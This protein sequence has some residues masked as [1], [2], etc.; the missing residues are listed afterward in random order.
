MPRPIER[1]TLSITAFPRRADLLVIGGGLGGVA[2]AMTAVRLGQTVILVERGDWLGGQW[3]AQAVPPDESPWVEEVASDSY[4]RLRETVRGIYRSQY[5]LTAHARSQ[6]RLNPGLGSVS[7]LTHEPRVGAI[8]IES[9]L[10]P[11]IATGR[12]TVLRHRE[13]VAVHRD[14][15]RIVAVDVRDR[16]SGDV[17]SLEG[18][19]VVDATEL[20]DL[21]ELGAFEF[22]TGAESR[23]ETGE[24]H[25]TEAADPLDQQA[26]SWCFAVEHRPGEDH[27]IDRPTTYAHWRDTHDPRWPGSQL[28]WVDVVP[29][30]LEER[31]HSIF[32]GDPSEADTPDGDDFWHF[33][34][35]IG[36]RNFGPEYPDVTLVN[37][38]QIDYWE[39]PL[40]GPGVDEAA[41][42]TALA[43]ARSLSE[44]FLYWM[45]TEAPRADGGTG[46]PGLRL[47]PDVVGTED[48]FAMEAYVRESRRI[49]ALF[50]VTEAHIGREMRGDAGAET[51]VDTVGIGSYRIDLHPSTSGRTYVDI[52]CHPFQIPLG[53]L[54]PRDADNLI[55]ANKNIGTTHITNGAYRLHPVE[56]S[57][58]EAAGVL[59]AE[60]LAARSTPAAVRETRTAEVQD[61]L[62]RLGA[63]LEWPEHIR[64]SGLEHDSIRNEAVSV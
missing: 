21:L 58:G 11:A 49:K 60:A 26:I 12:L 32:A 53:A 10:S 30:T 6:E 34:R 43:G 19:M 31:Y 40:V 55:P 33:R 27:T 35:V 57:I 20:G 22:V 61:V 52:G 15:R 37:W 42:E 4:R 7:R 17:L 63:P 2:A 8:A 16:R 47:R 38:P 48:G 14:G 41:Q 45:Q 36:T 24:L 46:Y 1:E 23:A 51:F 9:M 44:S 39:K 56:W 13:P 64:T 50:T 59:A 29:Y 25:A 5:P 54:I 28:S 62:R 18:R 3:T